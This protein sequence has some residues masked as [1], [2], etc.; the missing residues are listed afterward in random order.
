MTSIETRQ[1]RIQTFYGRRGRMRPGRRD[2]LSRLLPTY[3]V[4]NTGEVIDQAEVFGRRA[5]LVL[6][7]GSGTG[8]ATATMA[9]ADPERDYLAAEVHAPGVARLLLLIEERGIANIRVAHG[10]ALELVEHR[11]AP[12]SLSAIHVFFPDPWPKS[13]HHKRRLFQPNHVALLRSRLAAGGVLHAVTDW[14]DYAEVM[15]ATLTDDPGLVNAHATWAPRPPHRPVTKY[16]R[17][18][19]RDLRPIFELAFR[20]VQA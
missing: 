18:A 15:L 1:H 8:D 3:G 10:D 2:A 20:R 14:P 6:E 9:A 16:E 11:L 4:G 7:I 13:R 12:E 17:R 5:P 19:L